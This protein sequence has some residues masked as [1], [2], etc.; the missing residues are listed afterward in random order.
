MSK[1]FGAF[2]NVNAG[3]AECEDST[4]AAQVEL[5]A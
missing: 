2:Q 5:V 4:G 1:A 3:E